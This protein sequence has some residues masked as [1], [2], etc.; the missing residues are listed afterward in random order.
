VNNA[1]L[2]ADTAAAAAVLPEEMPVNEVPDDS[3]SSAE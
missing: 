3:G 2:A 1:Q